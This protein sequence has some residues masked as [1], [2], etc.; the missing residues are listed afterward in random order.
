MSEKRQPV[1]HVHRVV[2]LSPQIGSED[3]LCFNVASAP[4]AEISL[5]GSHRNWPS[6]SLGSGKRGIRT[7]LA[8]S[9]EK[10]NRIRENNIKW[11]ARVKR[12]VAV[13]GR[14]FG[15]CLVVWIAC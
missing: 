5:R 15:F 12:K 9:L 4:V 1:R 2:A 14:S 8:A 3:S 10:Y 6:D 7:K 11:E 13:M